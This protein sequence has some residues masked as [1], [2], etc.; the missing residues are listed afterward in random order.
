M[1]SEN[2]PAPL[3]AAP[4]QGWS[5]L[6]RLLRENLITSE[7]APRL[8][9]K[10]FFTGARRRPYQEQFWV[11]LTLSVV[12]ATMGLLGDSTATV[13][14]AMIVAPLMTPIMATAAALVTG[15]MDRAARSLGL[16]LAGVTAVISL[17]WLM[18]VLYTGIIDVETNSQLSG[19]VAPR[20]IDLIA[21]LASG[22]AGAF[23]MSREDVADSLP[24]VA[25]AISLVPPLCVVGVMLS[26][27]DWSSA[28]GA[29]LLFIVNALAILLAGGGVL[30]GLGLPRA[31]IG[32]LRGSARRHAFTAIIVAIVVTAVPLVLTGRA[33]TQ[34]VLTERGLRR[35][36][37]AWSQGSHYEVIAIRALG[38]TAVVSMGGTGATPDPADLSRRIATEVGRPMD[39]VLETVPASRE[40]IPRTAP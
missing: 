3:P 21:A 1:T 17:S 22:A 38:D 31:T 12:I 28:G 20:L 11:L 39:I 29:L 27:G 18:G 40:V 14:G 25:I 9:Q 16:V 26:V 19:R 2:S 10:L 36:V 33:I 23:C 4:Q 6:S 24:G 7:T 37:V 15:R 5:I 32:Q 35:A 8:E 13:I 34:D 30:A